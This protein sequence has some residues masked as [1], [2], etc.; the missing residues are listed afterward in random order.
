[1]LADY[2]VLI[3]RDR[4]LVSAGYGTQPGTNVLISY[5]DDQFIGGARYFSFSSWDHPVD[6]EEIRS[7][8]LP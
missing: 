1:V 2:W 5:T 3:D 4:H 6:Y 7:G 8:N